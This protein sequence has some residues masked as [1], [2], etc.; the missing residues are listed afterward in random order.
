M[1]KHE[2]KY[3]KTLSMGIASTGASWRRIR[4]H[5]PRQIA[6]AAGRVCH[7]A[8]LRRTGDRWTAIS[9]ADL[10][11]HLLNENP[12]LPYL[13]ISANY[14]KKQLH[15]TPFFEKIQIHLLTQ[16]RYTLIISHTKQFT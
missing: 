12:V 15:V 9:L 11:F 13:K 6:R 2:K 5:I 3:T 14:L 16:K 10:L 1:R 8:V 7:A 4:L